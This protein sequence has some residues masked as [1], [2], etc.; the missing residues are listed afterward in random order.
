MK[1]RY[2]L[3]L[4]VGLTACKQDSPNCEIKALKLLGTHERFMEVEVYTEHYILIKDFSRSCLDSALI[5]NAALK[6]K[7]TTGIVQYNQPIAMPANI[8]RFYN[9]DKDFIL[10][11]ISW[12][13]K[14]LNRSCLVVIIF[15]YFNKKTK[16]IF[17]NNKGDIIYSGDRW[18][19]YVR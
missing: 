2:F 14:K 11:K 10:N 17:Y 3:V 13:N 1:K 16:Y 19:K 18:I 8:L 7:D 4:L 9:S 6:Y 12:D 5:V 15:G